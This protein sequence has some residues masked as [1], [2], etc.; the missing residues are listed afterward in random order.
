LPEVIG[1]VIGCEN[2]FQYKIE[3]DYTKHKP[4]D[5]KK[6]DIVY[7]S[8]FGS[9][10]A[11]GIIINEKQ[12]LNKKWLTVYLLE[13]NNAPLKINLKSQKFVNDS[14]TIFS[15]DNTVYNLDMNN[16]DE[17][18]RKIIQGNYLFKNINSFI[19]Y[20]AD[21]SD[22]NKIRFYSLLDVTSPKRDLLREG[23]VVKTEIYGE[24]TLYQIID[25]KTHKEEL[26]KHNIYGYMV[27]IAQK[28]GKYNETRKE[29]EVVKWLPNIYSPVFFDETR[30]K[31]K[32]VLAVGRLPETE[33]EIL[34]KDFDSLITH[35]TAILGILGIGKSCL[36]FEL[37]KKIKEN[38]DTKIICIDITNEYF[39]E[40]TKYD[41]EPQIVND[42]TLITILS[43]NYKNID[44]DTFRGGNHADFRKGYI[45]IISSFLDGSDR[46][47]VVNPEAYDVSKQADNIKAK[48]I[49]PGKDE[50]ED[51]AP[52]VDL[53]IAEKTRIITEVILDLCK[54]K[55]KTKEARCLVVF[56]EA[57]SLIPEWNSAANKGDESASNGTARV[58][59]QGR[60][61]GL[62]CFIITQRTANVSKSILNQCN[63]IFSMRIFDDTGKQFLENYIGSDYSNILPTLEERHAVAVGKALNIK[64]PVI[65]KLNDKD[66]ICSSD[67]N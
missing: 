1:E 44:K 43:E 4:K 5:T 32:S 7:L 18:F 33:L 31:E 21:G 45:D 10:G 49:G 39:D 8:L 67:S 27:G 66:N 19:G 28:L 17:G 62:G 54:N 22:I 20:I 51:Q 15:K 6:G 52:M 23:T 9:I 16:I 35:N 3:I 55:G 63:T 13:H 53:T 12:L 59:L 50:W 65:I 26:D 30:L 25:G 58:I 37:I 29:L 60:K 36:S 48:K 14:G 42:E 11:V 40:L 57:H 64:Q 46:V 41:C 61:Y 34:L 24:K 2:P 38:S 56:E 47:L